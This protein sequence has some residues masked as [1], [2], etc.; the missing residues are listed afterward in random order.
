[1][2]G[3]QG[4]LHP[5]RRAQGLQLKLSSIRLRFPT[6]GREGLR[7]GFALFVDN[8]CFTLPYPDQHLIRH[9]TAYTSLL[10]I[11]TTLP[12]KEETEA[13][14]D[15]HQEENPQTN[16]NSNS[17]PM[18]KFTAIVARPLFTR[19]TSRIRADQQVTPS[20]LERGNGA[21]N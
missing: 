9:R 21:S 13:K 6:E 3:T 14:P 18:S 1:M 11:T 8:V 7:D 2:L 17:S 20:E 4:P 5:K 16:D 19:G 15:S 10:R 12:P